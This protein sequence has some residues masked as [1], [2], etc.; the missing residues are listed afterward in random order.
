MEQLF[1]LLLKYLFIVLEL[2]DLRE[3]SPRKAD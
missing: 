2:A 1:C 3:F